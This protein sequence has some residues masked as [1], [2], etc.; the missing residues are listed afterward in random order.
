MGVWGPNFRHQIKAT[1][2]ADIQGM[3]FNGMPHLCVQIPDLDA[4]YMVADFPCIKVRA[5]MQSCLIV[6]CR[7][8]SRQTCSSASKCSSKALGGFHAG[9][10]KHR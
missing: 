10:C 7:P 5:L 9:D 4:V 3:V 8:V 1:R 6:V 2:C